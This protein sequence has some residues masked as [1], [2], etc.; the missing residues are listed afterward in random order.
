MFPALLVGFLTAGPP[1]KSTIFFN[2]NTIK[3]QYCD[4]FW[5]T[6]SDKQY[7]Y[8]LSYFPIWFPVRYWA[9]LPVWYSR[10]LFFFI[11]FICSSL[12]PLIPSSQFITPQ[13]FLLWSPWV[14]FLCVGVCFW[15]ANE[16]MCIRFQIPQVGDITE[17]CLS[18]SD[19]TLY[20]HLLAHSC[21]C[22][23]H[24]VIFLSSVLV[25]VY[26]YTYKYSYIYTKHIFM[27]ASIDGHLGGSSVSWLLQTVLL[28]P[29]RCMYLFEL[30]FSPDLSPGMWLLVIW[31][32]NF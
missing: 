29:L 8:L 5:C 10:T 3:Y 25:C 1:R 21:C 4:S 13:P 14:C 27:C 31:W 11:Y 17:Y 20:D 26:I 19:F 24:F 23:W 7:V 16:F 30:E 22:K 12:Y 9:V 15:F 18:V 28:W 2:W 6:V 32:L